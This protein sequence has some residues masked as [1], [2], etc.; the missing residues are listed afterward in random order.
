[1]TFCSN[2]L[3]IYFLFFKAIPEVLQLTVSAFACIQRRYL[4]PEQ[5]SFGN[6]P[7]SQSLLVDHLQVVDLALLFLYVLFQ[8]PERAFELHAVSEEMNANGLVLFVDML[9]L[10]H[11][12]LHAMDLILEQTHGLKIIKIYQ[13]KKMRYGITCYFYLYHLEFVTFL[14]W[15]TI[16]FTC[17]V[18]HGLHFPCFFADGFRDKLAMLVRKF[19][20]FCLSLKV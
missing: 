14:I 11:V 13:E 4:L 16:T 12:H 3:Y 17:L 6:I 7:Q 19:L 18:S 8:F 1:M 20:Q 10:H 5:R 9:S 15:K 2:F